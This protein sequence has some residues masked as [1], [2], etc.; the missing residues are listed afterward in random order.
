MKF[1]QISSTCFSIIALL[2]L[3][4]LAG[5]AD[6]SCAVIDRAYELGIKQTNVHNAVDLMRKATPKPGDKVLALGEQ[7]TQSIVMGKTHYYAMDGLTFDLKEL[8]NNDERS[9]QTGLFVFAMVDEGCR[10]LGK[11]TIAGRTV[12]V[13]EHGSNKGPEN[14]YFKFW[15]DSQT[16]LP[17]KGLEDGPLPESKS[18]K[19]KDGLP[20]FGVVLSKTDRVLNTTAFV[21]GDMVKPPVLTGKKTLFGQKGE[22]D[23]TARA[24]LK[25]IIASP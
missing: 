8:K 10:S 24:K 6:K 13:F 22:L 14:R 23:P 15:V 7:M 1:L 9:M 18:T 16:G 3:S 5:A 25:E 11:A 20:V 19:G 21:Y 12:D 17:L 2:S 4:P